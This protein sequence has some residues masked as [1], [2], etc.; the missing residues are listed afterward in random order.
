[1]GCKNPLKKPIMKTLEKI[2]DYISFKLYGG[3]KLT[4]N[5]L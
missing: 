4:P 1:M 3:K 2:Y 5:E